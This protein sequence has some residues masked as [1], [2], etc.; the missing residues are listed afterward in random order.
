MSCVAA[1]YFE[2]REPGFAEICP[3]NE[4]SGHT[5]NALEREMYTSY[6]KTVIST[7][8]KESK[9]RRICR[10]VACSPSAE[11]QSARRDSIRT[12]KPPRASP[13]TATTVH[14]LHVV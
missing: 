4:F 1:K 2:R 11:S 12:Q 5:H 7:K 3:D 13:I 6:H 9:L 10:R 8:R 14:V